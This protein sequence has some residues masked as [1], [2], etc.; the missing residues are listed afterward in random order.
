MRPVHS[1][2]IGA[3]FVVQTEVA[4]PKPVFQLEGGR[5]RSRVGGCNLLFLLLPGLEEEVDRGGVERAGGCPKVRD[6]CT[7]PA[8]APGGQEEG[9]AEVL[10]QVLGGRERGLIPPSPAL[11]LLLPSG[12]Q[13]KANHWAIVA[14]CSTEHVVCPPP[15]ER[16]GRCLPKAGF[17][18]P[19]SPAAEIY[20][21]LAL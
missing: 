10:P 8:R 18:F 6:S 1:F 17:N 5:N 21:N 9:A 3:L 20:K 7:L 15:T 16:T 2:Q 19:P 11:Y 4:G 13:P 14:C 12:F